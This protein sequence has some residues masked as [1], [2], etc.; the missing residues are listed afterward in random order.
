MK[1]HNI[2][3]KARIL[4]LAL[5][6]LGMFTGCTSTKQEENTI[7][8]QANQGIYMMYQ[9]DLYPIISHKMID[10]SSL[11]T[12][13]ITAEK[14]DSTLMENFINQK[15]ELDTKINVLESDGVVT[16]YLNKQFELPVSVHI[17]ISDSERELIIPYEWV[18]GDHVQID[19]NNISKDTVY[20][21]Q[22]SYMK[23]QNNQLNMIETVMFF[24]SFR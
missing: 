19:L 4:V 22:V 18:D 17:I 21:I 15:K 24:M 5:V 20:T 3:S 9:N 7:T 8:L 11:V 6:L 16:L 1:K 12:N 14:V 23:F 10:N 13:T 2:V